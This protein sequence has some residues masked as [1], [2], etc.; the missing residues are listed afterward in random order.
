MS[1]L[2]DATAVR[3]RLWVAAASRLFAHV[4]LPQ[5]TTTEQCP[6]CCRSCVRTLPM[7]QCATCTMPVTIL[8]DWA[9][10]SRQAQQQSSSAAQSHPPHA[11]IRRRQPH[12]TNK[13]MSNA[14]RNVRVPCDAG[15]CRSVEQVRL[16]SAQ[17]MAQGHVR[18]QSF[19]SEAK[20]RQQEATIHNSRRGPG[21]RTREGGMRHREAG[22]SPVQHGLRGQ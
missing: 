13:H 18:I 16:Q 12:R 20:P 2:G 1:D 22:P 19:T 7:C 15:H 8:F 11:L 14:G 6:A 10:S 5:A 9:G 21:P 17:P 3:L 4:V